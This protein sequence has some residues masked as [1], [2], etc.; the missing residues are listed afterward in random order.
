[1]GITSFRRSTNMA[2][3]NLS[4]VTERYRREVNEYDARCANRPH[5][6]A[7]PQNVQEATLSCTLPY[8]L[9]S[10]LRRAVEPAGRSVDRH[11]DR[12]ARFVAR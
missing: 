7:L 3:G 10:R 6:L 2:T 1:M 4:S 5:D 11:K 12:V 8:Q 9:S